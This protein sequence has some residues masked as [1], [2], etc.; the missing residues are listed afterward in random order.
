MNSEEAGKYI[1][2]VNDSYLKILSEDVEIEKKNKKRLNG[3]EP[4]K[5]EEA[6]RKMLSDAKLGGYSWETDK[7]DDKKKKKKGKNKTGRPV[8]E[9]KTGKLTEAKVKMTTVYLNKATKKS[10]N[11][12][13]KW[14]KEKGASALFADPFH[15][16]TAVSVDTNYAEAMAQEF[17]DIVKNM[18]GSVDY[19]KKK[20]ALKPMGG[21][22]GKITKE[23]GYAPDYAEMY[24]G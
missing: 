3:M 23:L 22:S 16:K 21:K 4:D 9:D 15:T 12:L 17:P 11:E 2:D 8:K 6:Y 10:R 5:V 13:M 24:K 19:T 18:G 20:S 1:K 14:A 7:D